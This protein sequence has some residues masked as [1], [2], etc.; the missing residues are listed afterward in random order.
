MTISLPDKLTIDQSEKY[1]LSIRL[2][3]DGLSFSAY[4]P[5]VADSFL[6]RDIVFE[7]ELPYLSSL[8]ECF[9]NNEFFSWTYKKTNLIFVDVPYVLTPIPFLAEK[10]RELYLSFIHSIQGGRTVSNPLVNQDACL[11]FE[12]D[13]QLYEFCS[14]S[15]INPEPFHALTPLITLCEKV[16]KGKSMYVFLRKETMDMVCFESGKLSFL[17]TFSYK[18][19]NDVL[20]YVLYNWQQ[21]HMDQLTD[22]IYIAGELVIQQ[23]SMK[24]FSTYLH[25]VH[26][27]DIPSEA[28]LQGGEIV[29]APMDLIALS[30]C[31]L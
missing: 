14:R 16:K 5:L 27:V 18:H 3:P 29:Q 6:Y 13:R 19:L 15:L 30:I 28:Y 9:F 24:A 2:R 17:N 1:I 21:T 26:P 4:N 8:Q 31:G 7:K 11:V 22:P 25:Q 12:T 10:D 20:Y 23:E